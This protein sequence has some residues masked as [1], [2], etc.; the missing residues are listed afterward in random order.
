MGKPTRIAIGEEII[1]LA[2]SKDFFIVNT[3]TKSSGLY[4]F[5]RLYPNREATV[6]IAEQN[7]MAIAAGIGSEGIKVIVSTFAVFLSLRALEQIRSFIAYPKINVTILAS[8][9][10]LQVG[11]DGATHAA[12]EDLSIMLAIPNITI[13]QPSDEIS[14]RAISEFAVDFTGPLYIRLHRN[15]VENIH[16]SD[17]TFNFNTPDIIRNSGPDVVIMST[18]II[19]SLGIEIHEELNKR[20]IAS[21]LIDFITI[22][23]LNEE[24][25]L[26]FAEEAKLIVT[27][28][29]NNVIGGFGA[30]ISSL[31]C[32][33]HPI[34]VLKF[35]IQDQF[36]S[37]GDP[38]ELYKNNNMDLKS[39]VGK[40]SSFLR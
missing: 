5:Q 2:K 28:E 38:K 35:G 1:K 14:A 25:V 19:L 10:G 18:G 11:G 30:E 16:T 23:P 9:T 26:Q 31:L 40:I 13:L 32:E 6:G 33:H 22:K 7:M 4:N 21:T 15:T 39:I 8:H 34:R 29:D 20:G 27:L 17:Y 24:Q 37:S 3:D 12:I 36:S